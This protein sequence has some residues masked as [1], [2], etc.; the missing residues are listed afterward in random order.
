MRHCTV[1]QHSTGQLGTEPKLS[2]DT[3]SLCPPLHSLV[4]CAAQCFSSGCHLPLVSVCAC[5]A[6]AGSWLPGWSKYITACRQLDGVIHSI[7][8]TTRAQQQ[9]QQHASTP[10]SSSGSP[11]PSRQTLVSFL[12]A[13]Q[14][15]QGPDAIPD[16]HILSEIKTVMFGGTDTSA[17]TLAMCAQYL[18]QHPAA[19]ARGAAEVAA[20]LAAT[21]RAGVGELRAED[22]GK[23]PWVTACVNETMRLAPAGPTI[24]RIALQVRVLGL[25]W[26]KVDLARGCFAALMQRLVRAGVGLPAAVCIRECAFSAW[27][28]CMMYH[29]AMLFC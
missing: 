18:A 3:A 16:D 21:G 13:A 5:V 24:T 1:V 6:A 12:L 26:G 28:V 17:F 7:L 10:G 4:A 29:A 22:A 8:Q 23:L 19:A 9:Q 2:P 20:L 27:C 11:S 15:Q 25:G 14:E